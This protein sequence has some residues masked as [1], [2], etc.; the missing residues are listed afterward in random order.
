MMSAGSALSLFNPQI[1]ILR[2]Y[3][4]SNDPRYLLKTN[5]F[6]RPISPMNFPPPLAVLPAAGN[7]A[8]REWAALP[9]HMQEKF[10][11]SKRSRGQGPP[12][13]HLR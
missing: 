2:L 5:G 10:P 1:D 3:H 7:H 9:I 12:Y 4:Q 11:D 6:P 8:V 13:I